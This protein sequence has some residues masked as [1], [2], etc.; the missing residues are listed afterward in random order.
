MGELRHQ[1]VF[2]QGTVALPF[3]VDVMGIAVTDTGCYVI[4]FQVNGIPFVDKSSSPDGFVKLHHQHGT[5]TIR[6]LSLNNIFVSA[7]V[8]QYANSAQKRASLKITRCLWVKFYIFAIIT[9]V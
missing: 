1:A 2:A 7:A 3:Q 4:L 8:N 9:C 5:F 6:K